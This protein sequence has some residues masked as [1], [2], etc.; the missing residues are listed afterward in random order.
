MDVTHEPTPDRGPSEQSLQ[1]LRGRLAG[2]KGWRGRLLSLPTPVRVGAGLVVLALTALAVGLAMRRS[3]F[4]AYPAPL[5]AVSLALLAAFA[6]LSTRVFLWPLHARE[7]SRLAAG[8]WLLLGLGFPVLLA[9][10]PEA[11][12]L[13]HE[14]PESFEGRGADFWPRAAGCLVFGMATSLPLLALLL[15]ADRRERRSAARLAFA[16]AAAGLAGNLMLL[17]HCPLVAREHLLVGHVGV[18]FVVLLLLEAVAWA[19]LR[20]M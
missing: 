3:D 4:A 1:Q 10:L 8:G 18:G 5:M 19:R 14:H 20:K 11:H 2:E 6:L 17:L 13:V 16:A 9:M 15:L 7:P 12:G